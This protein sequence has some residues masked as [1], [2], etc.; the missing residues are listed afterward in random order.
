M[1]ELLNRAPGTAEATACGT[2]P[3]LL[4]TRC[5]DRGIELLSAEPTDEYTLRLCVPAR[6][7]GALRDE[8]ERCQ[9]ALTAVR[10]LGGA[11]LSRSLR[12][13]LLPAALC[14]THTR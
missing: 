12:R 10:A 5:A 13:R 2:E 6:Q 9:C 4:L 8:A 3:A 14:S 11:R 1:F 7:L